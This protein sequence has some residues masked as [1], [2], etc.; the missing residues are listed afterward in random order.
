MALITKLT[1][2]KWIRIIYLFTDE[3]SKKFGL[4]KVVMVC[5]RCGDHEVLEVELKRAE[6]FVTQTLR[7]NF[8]SCHRNC[9]TKK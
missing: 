1:T 3:A 5:D 4:N 6:K 7:D 9:K 8:E 2:A